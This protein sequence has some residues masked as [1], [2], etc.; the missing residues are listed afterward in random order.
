MKFKSLK[1]VTIYPSHSQSDPIQNGMENLQQN[2]LT[3]SQGKRGGRRGGGGLHKTHYSPLEA[4]VCCL[5]PN[6]TITHWECGSAI[7]DA[8]TQTKF[9]INSTPQTVRVHV[10]VCVCERES[11]CSS[12]INN[13]CT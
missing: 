13:S 11:P 7:L 2:Y 12:S 9:W 4:L 5:P 8:H 1:G 6:Y 10:S 3:L